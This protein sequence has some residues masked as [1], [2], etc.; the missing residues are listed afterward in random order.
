MRTWEGCKVNYL[1]TESMSAFKYVKY[2]LRMSFN[3]AHHFILK[4]IN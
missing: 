3:L 4:E 2:P 1:I